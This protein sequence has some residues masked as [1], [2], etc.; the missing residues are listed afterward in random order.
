MPAVQHGQPY[1]LGPRRWGIRYYINGKRVRQSPFD[2]RSEA[3]TWYRRVIEP[4]LRG[5]APERPD[6]TLAEFIHTYLERHAVTVRPRTIA[7][8]RDRLRHAVAAFGDVPLRELERMSDEIAGWQAQ[9]PPRA[10]HGIAQALRQVLDAAVRWEY[11]SRNPAKLAGRN[12]KS[13]PRAIRAFT[14]AELEAIA[15]ELSPA[16][17][18]LPSFAAATGL[19]P[20]EWQVLERG[21]VDRRARILTVRRTLSSRKVVELAKTSASRRQVPLSPRAMTALEQIPPRLDVPRLWP[22]PEGGLLN[23]TTSVAGSGCPRSRRAGFGS[24]R[25]SMTCARHSPRTRSRPGSRCSSL[26]E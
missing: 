24:R 14:L 25:V 11:T 21:D 15:A 26:L 2:S 12:P 8:L 7:T 6:P 20:E 13:P 5:E 16:Y 23:W 18:P 3:L 17:Q 22:A 10:G 9:L 1:R 4:Q 19:R